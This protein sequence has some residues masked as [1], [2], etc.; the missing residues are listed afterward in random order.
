MTENIFYFLGRI[1]VK[2]YSLFAFKI[3]VHKQH[4]FPKG[5]KIFVANHPSTTDPF[6]LNILVKEK[7]SILIS[8]R[9]FDFPFFGRYLKL[10]GHIPVDFE[11]GRIAFEN[12]KKK[13]KDGISVVIFMEGDVS[14]NNE[15]Q[16]PKTGAVRL[17]IETGAPIV[18]LSFS[19][20]H[21][22]VK[23]LNM[24]TSKESVLAHW[25]LKGPYEIIFGKHINL[26]GSLEDREFIKEQS[27]TIL[28][29]IFKMSFEGNLRINKKTKIIQ[30]IPS[31]QHYYYYRY[32]FNFFNLFFFILGSMWEKLHNTFGKYL[33]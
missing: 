14:Q 1:I 31:L 2:I 12:A 25:Y 5:V 28:E 4:K 18:P 3:K 13:L 22:R 23:Y 29:G 7:V 9:L 20:D 33:I 27:K 30:P 24:D 10:A 15:F 21:S 19:L 16:K 11:N 6:L 26:S 8:K 17:A 32:A